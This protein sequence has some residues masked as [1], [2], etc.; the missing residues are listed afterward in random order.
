MK[1]IKFFIITIL[2]L[3]NVSTFAS[4]SR[5]LSAETQKKLGTL[6]ATFDGKLGIYAID[7]NN[8]EIIKYRANERFP[9]QSTSKLMAVSALLKKSSSDKNLLQEKIDYTNK[10]LLPYSSVTEKNVATGM[11]L[12]SLAEAAMT[13]SD[14]TAMNLIT[15]KLGGPKV[16]TKFS[17][18]IGNK[19]FNLEHYE[20][21]LNSNPNHHEDTSTPKDMAISVEK[22]MLGNVLTQS[23]RAELVTWMKNNTVGHDK[24]RAGVPVG[25]IVA[26]K[27]GGGNYGVANDIGVLWPPACKPV[28]L[29]IYTVQN[30]RDAQSR[31]DILTKAT[32]I[33]VKAFAKND[34][35][36]T[37]K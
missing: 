24:I 6:E 3:I 28:V 35:C 15:K 31:D 13:F 34:P 30:K 18:T 16:I 9:F 7:T 1:Y 20:D 17:N 4:T 23:Q 36:F 19:T 2:F 37:K 29:A 12:K 11:T 33:V 10:D 14:N 26:D 21:H 32:A 8:N 25:W 22:L 5:S 27:T